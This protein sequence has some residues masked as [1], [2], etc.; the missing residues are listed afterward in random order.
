[1]CSSV[2]NGSTVVHT[3]RVLPFHTSSTSRLSS[4]RMKR[5]FSG[6]GLALLDQ[7]DQVALLGVGEVVGLLVLRAIGQARLFFILV[8]TEGWLTSPAKV[9]GLCCS[10]LS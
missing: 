9:V 5:Y 6:S 10:K 7:V 2:W 3:S 8:F 1:M 4:N